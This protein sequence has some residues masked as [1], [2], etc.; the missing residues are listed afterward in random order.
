MF[1]Q[2]SELRAVVEERGL[3]GPLQQALE[4]SAAQLGGSIGDVST[5]APIRLALHVDCDRAAHAYSDQ[6]SYCPDGLSENSRIFL[7]TTMHE[8]GHVLN[9]ETACVST[10]PFFP[11]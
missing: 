2:T 8:L 6:I 7:W 4:A 10:D 1:E 5:N 9:G 3:A 11:W